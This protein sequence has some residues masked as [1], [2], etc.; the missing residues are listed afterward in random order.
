M[1]PE[2]AIFEDAPALARAAADRITSALAAALARAPSASFVLTGG[3]TPAPTYERL[4]SCPIDWPRL[5]IFWSDERAVGPDHPESNYG[6]TRRTLLD[7]VA[8]IEAR[9]HRMR[10][11]LKLRKEALLYALEIRRAVAGYPT[12][13]FDLVLLGLGDDGHTA[14]LFPGT[15]WEES[16]LVEA[17]EVPKL[18]VER[19]TMTPR[20]LNAARAVVFLV[21]GNAKAEAVA[22]VLEDPRSAAPARRIAPEHGTLTWMLDRDA[23]AR[24]RRR[25]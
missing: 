13:R 4:R 21:S 10:G 6:M 18:G 11:E 19:I 14:S 3:S 24:L 7:S 16:S 17:V 15:E 9:V 22:S 2:I 1:K 23:A 20:L 12:P 5:E 25:T 8:I